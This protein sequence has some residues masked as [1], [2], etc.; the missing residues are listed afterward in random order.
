MRF[1]NLGQDSS[2]YISAAQNANRSLQDILTE[3]R[4][5]H[6]ELANLNNRNDAVKR[7]AGTELMA[8][9]TNLV[10][11]SFMDANKGKYAAKVIEARGAEN[12]STADS[13]GVSNLVQGIGGGIFEGLANRRTWKDATVIG[14]PGNQVDVNGRLRY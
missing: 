2:N 14:F 7:M 6:S 1:T 5:D 8:N 4:P 9:L 11:N 12:A 3:T 13:V 10:I